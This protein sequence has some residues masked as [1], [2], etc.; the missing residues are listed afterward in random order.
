ML[1]V[2]GSDSKVA[3]REGSATDCTAKEPRRARPV[4]RTGSHVPQRPLKCLFVVQGEGRGHMTQ[5]IALRQLLEEA[6]HEV[7]LTMVGKSRFRSLP[8]FFEE[9]MGGTVTSFES[10][11]LVAD[12]RGQGVSVTRT[13]LHS[14][15]SLPSYTASV[16]RIRREI[17]RHNPDVVI[18]FFDLMCSISF[19]LRVRRPKHVCIGHQFYFQHP[20]FES[21][22]GGRLGR[23]ALRVLIRCTALRSDLRLALSYRAGEPV[24]HGLRV[25]APLIRS[26][27]LDA[28][29]SEG[30]HLLVYLLNPGYAEQIED[31][32]RANPGQ[33]IH[34]F[35]DREGTSPETTLAEGLTFHVL[36]DR[37]FVHL[38]SG[39]RALVT[40]AGFESVC[41]AR[42]LGKPVLIVATEGHAE[43]RCNAAD[44]HAAGAAVWADRFDFGLLDSMADDASD[45]ER[46]RAWVDRSRGEPVRLIEDVVMGR[47][48][49]V[50]DGA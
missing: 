15:L 11:V 9:R 6:G 31:W 20:D 8:R 18:N 13:A 36:D 2:L 14:V 40:T 25:V 34:G 19:L 38:L 50:E 23:L 44:A 43:Q 26:E 7:C 29:A 30:P 17:S 49:F 4:P 32:H 35:W 42:Y 24:G 41:E 48:G 39:C 10:P 21:P 5:A 3:I 28:D 1:L 16:F 33:E 37:K 27:I 22:P 12:R 46:F 47:S 45:R